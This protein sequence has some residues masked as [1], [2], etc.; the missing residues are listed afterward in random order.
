MKEK[1]MAGRDLVERFLCRNPMIAPRKVQNLN[2]RR[3][4]KFNRFIVNDYL[5]KLYISMKEPGVMNKP[6]HIY[7]D[8]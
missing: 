7:N 1:G 4:Q 2:P 6:E 3:A 5:A 8:D